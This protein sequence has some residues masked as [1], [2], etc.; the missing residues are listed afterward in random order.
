MVDPVVSVATAL[1]R[2]QLPELTLREGASVT[3]RVASRGEGHGVLV[4][5]GIPLT[6]QL[7]DGVASGATLKL[8][9]EEVSPERV[10][11]RMD[12]QPA[13]A[14]TAGPAAPRPEAPRLAVGEPPR[15]APAGEDGAA[16]VALAF[17]SPALGRLDLRIDLA[18]GAVQVGVE[19][20]AGRAFEAA[21]G[22]AERLRATLEATLERPAAV[23][24]TPRREP[25]DVY[26]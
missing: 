21:D 5:A 8:R 10:V 20:P 24:V 9:I 7:P 18:S 6:A 3:A 11:L 17:V 12:G 22:G 2:A 16:S 23:R 26:A 25:L 15:R 14:P 4:L 1:L 19:A 13:E